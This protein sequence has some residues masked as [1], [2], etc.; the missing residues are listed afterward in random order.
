MSQRKALAAC[1]VGI[2]CVIVP[3]R[4]FDFK[5]QSVLSFDLVRV[6]RVHRTQ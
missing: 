5:R 3:Q 6:V 4:L 1:F 2:F